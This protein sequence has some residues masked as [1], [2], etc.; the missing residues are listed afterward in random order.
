MTLKEL[1]SQLECQGVN[2]GYVQGSDWETWI[3]NSF[4][5][6]D[7]EYETVEENTKKTKSLVLYLLQ[8]YF[9]VM[10]EAYVQTLQE[11]LEIL[12]EDLSECKRGKK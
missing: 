12:R 4:L 11:D 10:D 9:R 2:P 8:E 3:L 6:G 1:A 5:M 7:L